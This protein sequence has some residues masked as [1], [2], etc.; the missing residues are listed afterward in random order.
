MLM[1]CTY[2]IYSGS[3]QC[4]GPPIEYIFKKQMSC[5]CLSRKKQTSKNTFKAFITVIAVKHHFF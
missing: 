3:D 1:I 5:L 2:F 4:H